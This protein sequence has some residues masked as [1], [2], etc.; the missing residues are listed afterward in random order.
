M[1]K[2]LLI[3][4]NTRW[5]EKGYWNDLPYG[6]CILK[7]TLKGKYNVKVLDANFHNLNELEIKERS[8]EYLPDVVGITCMSFE[9]KKTLFLT[10][11]LIKKVLPDVPIVVGGIFP[12]L[13]PEEIICEKEIDYVI[14]GEGEFRFEAL[15][16]YLNDKTISI[17][18]IDGLAYKR[19]NHPIFQNVKNYIEDLDVVPLPDYSELDY[20][21]Y[22][23]SATKYSHY[24]HPLRF[25]YGRI[26]T[27]RGCPYDCIFCCSKKINGDKIRFRSPQAVLSEIDWLVREYG[28]KEIIFYDD[29]LIINR[30][31]IVE[32]LEGLIKRNYDLQWK[33]TSI[34]VYA[35]DDDLLELIRKSGC[36]Q[37]VLAL[38][39]GTEEGLKIMKKPFRRL[40]KTEKV[41]TKAK[42][43]GFYLSAGFVFGLPGETWEQILR[44]FRYAESLDIDYCTFGVATPLPKTELY[45][46]CKKNN[47]LVPNF[48]FNDESFTGFGKPSICT[49]EFSPFEL[50][51]LRAFE[52]D[53]INFKSTKKIERIALMH[54]ITVEEVNQW[55]KNTRE[56]ALEVIKKLLR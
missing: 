32:I 49:T 18:S 4:L 14:M 8:F 50:A 41:I 20:K 7:A 38:E 16:Q 9:Y 42:S 45:E 6:L 11:Q 13:L 35:L 12:T 29:N 5:F 48:S 51:I 40:E 25:P 10:A 17:E 55:R 37:L 56:N 21:A 19:N 2:I 27:S 34:A 46:I 39:S 24:T 23:S 1:Q 30:K 54:S 31:R 3:N 36:Y 28:V 33:P 52:W 22:S 53:R 44:T 43:L 26:I 47:L 15:L